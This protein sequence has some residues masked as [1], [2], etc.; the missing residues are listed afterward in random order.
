ME[1]FYTFHL[2]YILRIIVAGLCG[3]AI[4]YE[5]RNRAKEAGVRTHSIV[6]CAAALMMIISKYGFTD[7]SGGG[8]GSRIAAQIVSGVGFLGAGMIYFQKNAVSGLTTA[9]GMWAVAGIGMAIGSKLYIE[10]IAFTFIVIVIQLVF[11]R[12]RNPVYLKETVLMIKNV[13]KDEYYKTI[14]P[15]LLANGISVTDMAV[16]KEN[17]AYEYK[18][19]VEYPHNVTEDAIVGLFEYD[20]SI[21]YY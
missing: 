1:W 6:A 4:G 16:K 21:N 15:E 12:D 8:D 10:G 2:N 11:R 18:L 5:R 19:T 17:G 3:M 9:A 13:E 14:L 7:I 20:A